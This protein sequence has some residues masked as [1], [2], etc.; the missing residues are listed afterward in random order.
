MFPILK[1]KPGKKEE[2]TPTNEKMPGLNHKG[3]KVYKDNDK[4]KLITNPEYI[5]ELE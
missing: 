1:V 3:T 2:V 5:K 4:M